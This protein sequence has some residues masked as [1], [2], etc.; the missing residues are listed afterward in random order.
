MSIDLATLTGIDAKGYEVLEALSF[1]GRKSS[2]HS[3]AH[4]FICIDGKTYWVKGTAQQGLVSELIGGRLA[5]KIGAGPVARIIRVTPEAAPVDGSANH[6]LGVV[7][8][9]EDEHNAVN[10]RDLG[11]LA[12]GAFE[13]KLID[14]AARALVVAFQTWIGVGD[15]QVLVNLRTGRIRSIDHGEC[16]M[17]TAQPADPVLSVLHIDGVPDN[18]GNDA[19]SLKVAADRI[20]AVT[21]Q[22]LLEAVARIPLGDPWKS[23]ASRRLEIASWLADRRGKVGE[24]IAKWA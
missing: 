9:L 13:P 23:P 14:P 11:L 22:Q 16:F 19:P 21:D 20:E 4:T 7:V 2:T 17:A 15:V 8:G 6:L 24:V 18:L 1:E 3:A 10:A 5:A 12:T